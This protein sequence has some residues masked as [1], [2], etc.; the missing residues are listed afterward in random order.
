MFIWKTKPKFIPQ[1]GAVRTVT[2]FA[3]LPTVVLIDGEEYTVWI[4]LYYT[5]QE[6]K[7]FTSEDDFKHIVVKM[8]WEDS[9]NWLPERV[10]KVRR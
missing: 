4:K 7:Y 8:Q 3:F 5:T 1:A 6:L 9:H 2:R 10:L